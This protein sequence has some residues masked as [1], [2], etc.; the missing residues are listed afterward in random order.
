MT[1]SEILSAIIWHTTG[2][3]EM[4]LLDKIVFIAD[5]IEVNS[6]QAEDLPEVRELALK[7]LMPACKRKV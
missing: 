1:D 2:C 3:P 7:I 4:S 5:Y 6:N